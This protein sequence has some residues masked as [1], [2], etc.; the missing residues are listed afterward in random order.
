[1]TLKEA[2]NPN[3]SF[4]RPL[5][6]AYYT[7]IDDY[8]ENFSGTVTDVVTQIVKDLLAD[9][10]EV[11][12]CK[13]HE[14]VIYDIEASTHCLACTWEKEAYTS[15]VSDVVEALTKKENPTEEEKKKM[16]EDFH[17]FTEQEIVEIEQAIG[18]GEMLGTAE[19]DQ[20]VA[21][22]QKA[23]PCKRCAPYWTRCRCE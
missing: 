19:I 15:K 6:D 13:E 5:H 9:D 16:S 8:M 23:E 11:L 14:T 1:M 21:E 2:I 17:G 10:W 4:K 20:L 3:F 12:V 22:Q 7:S 18:Q